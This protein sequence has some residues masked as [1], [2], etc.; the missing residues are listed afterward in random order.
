MYPHLAKL[1]KGEKKKEVNDEDDNKENENEKKYKKKLLKNDQKK[2]RKITQV[3]PLVLEKLKN[4]YNEKKR[5]KEKLQRKIFEE[6]LKV[7][8]KKNWEKKFDKI[9]EKH[10]M[11]QEIGKLQ[12]V[13]LERRSGVDTQILPSG[14]A[15]SF[16]KFHHSNHLKKKSKFYFSFDGSI[17]HLFTHHPRS[18]HCVKSFINTLNKNNFEKKSHYFRSDLF[19]EME[20]NSSD[21]ETVAYTS[22]HFSSTCSSSESTH[23]STIRTPDSLNKKST[24]HKHSRNFYTRTLSSSPIYL[25]KN[26]RKLNYGYNRS[27]EKESVNRKNNK[28][29][30]LRKKDEKYKS[31]I[32]KNLKNFPKTYSSRRRKYLPSYRNNFSD[33]RGVGEFF[34]E[35][36]G[37][38]FFYI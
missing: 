21:F 15:I 24:Y 3:V 29:I 38:F 37:V 5:E 36:F 26:L 7:E 16:H 33:L 11:K 23:L 20:N 2:K 6:E 13:G 17:S 32:Q 10:L 25:F 4:N 18:G 22:S 30:S 14:N 1:K 8:S 31:D 28:I 27:D 9:R 12:N 34:M 19:F 35:L